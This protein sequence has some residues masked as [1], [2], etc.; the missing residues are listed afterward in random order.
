MAV[1]RIK[2]KAAAKKLETV[3][4]GLENRQFVRRLSVWLV[5]LA[6]F[7]PSVRGRAKNLCDSLLKLRLQCPALD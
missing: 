4:A 6:A 1:S 3:S 2:W 5:L 7:R